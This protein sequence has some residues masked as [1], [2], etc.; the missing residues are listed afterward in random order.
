MRIIDKIL[1]D[2]TLEKR[3]WDKVDTSGDC[4][5]WLAQTT[6]NG[7]G[8]IKTKRYDG[9]RGSLTAHRYSLYLKTKTWPEKN[10]LACHTCDNRECVNPDH[11]FWGTSKENQIDCNIKGRRKLPYKNKEE[12]IEIKSRLASAPTRREAELIAQTYGIKKHTARAIRY[13]TQWSWLNGVSI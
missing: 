8:Q 13:G 2:E 1:G 4:W 6:P 9:K 12:A 7:Y 11:L 10:I 5:K 3:F